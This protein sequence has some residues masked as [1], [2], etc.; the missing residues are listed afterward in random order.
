MELQKDI[1]NYKRLSITLKVK[2][3]ITCK[4]CISKDDISEYCTVNDSK[5][6]HFVDN[7]PCTKIDDFT[8]Y[9]NKT[10]NL[11]GQNI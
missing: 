4:N 2:Y 8:I 5:F 1:L 11:H 9:F 3:S 6:V 7:L 10:Y